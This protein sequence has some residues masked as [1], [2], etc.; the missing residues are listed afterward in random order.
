MRPRA[1]ALTGALAY[2]AFLVATVP[3][4]W[5]AGR[6]AAATDGSVQL[7][8][9]TGTLWSGSG[10][11]LV[12]SAAGRLAIDRVEWRFAPAE[13]AGG[14]AAFDLSAT[15]RGLDAHLRLGRALSAWVAGPVAL[16]L[17]APLVASVLPV[18][19]AWRPEGRIRLSS[20]RFVWND[21]GR[22]TG[23]ARATWD[24]AAVSLSEVRPLGRYA[25]DA[26]ADNGPVN[27][28]L[29]TL[30]GALRIAGKGTFSAPARLSFSGEARGEG[31]A[32]G[33][34]EPLLGL[35][36]PRRADGSRAIEVRAGG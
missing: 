15:G 9:P 13:L 34:L 5:V 11:A 12:A 10:R 27:L 1:I 30:E 20:E 24:G 6:V 29:A 33:A 32:A 8:D 17:E 7:D 23:S 19:A 18:A 22:A 21:S 26:T 35:M 36:G 16:S 2:A 14:Q 31:T 25:L 28:T 4:S 3:A